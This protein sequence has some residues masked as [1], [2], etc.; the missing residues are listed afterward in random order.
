MSN[1]PRRVYNPFYIVFDAFRNLWR[2]RATG[3]AS[4]LVLTSCLIL[5]GAFGLLIRNIDVN[6]EKLGLLNE[7]VVF[8]D[9]DTTPEQLQVITE[10]IK[11]LDNVTYVKYVSKDEGFESMKDTYPDYEELFDDIAASG[12]NPLPDSF[13]VSYK[14]TAGANKLEYDLLRIEGVMKVNNR[15]DYAATIE[16]FKSGLSF[17]FVWFFALLL[18]VSVFVIFNTVK[19]A[20]HG[21]RDEISIMRFIGATKG[22]I[23]APFVIEGVTIGF[24]SAMLAFF[25]DMGIYNYVVKTSQA[26]TSQLSAMFTLIPYSDMRAQLLAVFLLLGIVTGVVASIVSLHKNLSN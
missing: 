3:I 2:H 20:V 7:I 6:V 17:V 24:I 10:D 11:S 25:I 21:R 18:A 4:V 23:I 5:L 15:V 14:D 19:L 26:G 8:V 1:K 22:Y 16:S 12:D 9:Y 13:I